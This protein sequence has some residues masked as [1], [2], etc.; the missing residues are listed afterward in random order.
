VENFDVSNAGY[1]LLRAEDFSSST[2]AWTFCMD[3]R[4]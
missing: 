2:V 4:G 1:S 3:A